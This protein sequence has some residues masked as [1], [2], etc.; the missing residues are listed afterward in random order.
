MKYE[1]KIDFYTD[2][3]FSFSYIPREMIYDGDYTYT[4]NKV[5][6]NRDEAIENVLEI[7]AFLKENAYTHKDYLADWWN[8]CIDEFTRKLK[9]SDSVPH[10]RIEINKYGNQELKISFNSTE[11][12]I[13][14]GFYATDEEIKLFRDNRDGITNEM[15]KEAILNLFRNNNK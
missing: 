11:D 7:C 1:F 15:V 12:Y 2:G 9:A 6:S 5:Y 8:A 3:D 10:E 13:T 4:L 14:C